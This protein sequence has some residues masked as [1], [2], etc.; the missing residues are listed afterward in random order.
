MAKE[1]IN[2]PELA[3]AR[4]Y[5]HGVKVGNTVYVAGQVAWGKDGKVV[6]EGDFAAQAHHV[7]GNIKTILNAGGADFKDV[8][9][10]NTYVTDVGTIPQ[11]REIRK[12]YFG[13]NLAASTAVGVTGLAAPGL[14]IEVEVIA[15]IGA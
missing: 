10:M 1:L 7:F 3:P 4:G 13:E 12:Q 11:L 9:K 6:G 14:L 5:S 8:V 2:P 15:E